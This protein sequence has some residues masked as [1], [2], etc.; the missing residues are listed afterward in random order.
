MKD[1]IIYLN[2][3]RRLYTAR[4]LLDVLQLGW[5]PD[6]QLSLADFCH[7][8]E[9]WASSVSMDADEMTT[10][11]VFRGAGDD[12]DLAT[13]GPDGEE[14]IFATEQE[15]TEWRDQ[16]ARSGSVKEVTWS[17]YGWVRKATS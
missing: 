9:Q 11:G 7:A 14:A 5:S 1:N 6:D 10:W 13:M 4:E 3:Y 17:D 12:P 16:N 15:A 8:A 2:G